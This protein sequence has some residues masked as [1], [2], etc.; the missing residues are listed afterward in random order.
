[1]PDT[2]SDGRHRSILRRIARRAMRERALLPD[3]SPAAL[4]EL[5]AIGQ[6]AS[7]ADAGTRDLRDLI[8]CS[9]DNDDSRD[10]DQ[11][12]VAQA[13]PDQTVKIFVAIADVDALVR[14][15]SALDDHAKQNTTSVYTA[16]EIF[17]MLPEKLSTNL[18]SLGER[19]DRL[20]LVVDMTT[21]PQGEVA[22]SDLYRAVV[23]NHAKLAYNAVAAWL[24]GAGPARLAAVRGLDAQLRIQDDVAQR[25]KR[26]R[27]ERGALTL[28]TLEVRP[29][30]AADGALED[31]R[32]DTKNRAKELIENFMI[33]ANV[34]TATFLDHANF[35]SL[36]RVLDTPTR[37]PRIV[38]LAA[39]S[40]YKLP[41]SA[42]AAALDAF[43]L[44]SR[45][46]DPARFAD[47]SLAVVKLLGSGA[48]AV[49]RPGHAAEGHFGLAVKDYAHSTAPNRRF[50]DLVTQRL[51]K[52]A[53]TGRSPPYSPSELEALAL[54]CTNQE[55]SATKVERQVQKSAAALLLAPR[56][57]KQFDG[58]VTGASAK[59]TW[60]RISS[61]TVEGRVVRGF[62]GLDVGDKVRVQLLR[63]DATHGFIDFAR[64][65]AMR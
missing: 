31:L 25:L 28:D 44:Q 65:G 47:V 19:D 64:A 53:L 51:V 50:P 60:V 11:L 43:L 18:T 9:I 63:A 52:A 5:E 13:L 34:S 16:A 30:F 14:K 6:P 41:A 8:W 15:E 57:G 22:S 58:I 36:R 2:T 55:D 61:P 33:A 46:R 39:A 62:E 37:W 27:H 59:G 1:M 10:L 48:Y 7:S 23:R 12:T 17:P 35:P 3:F 42:D 4:A 54:H 40:G 20:A 26:S 49:E 32:P 45:N 21:T 38:E 56:I 24:D 29:V